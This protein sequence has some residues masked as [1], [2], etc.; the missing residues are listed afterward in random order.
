[1][2]QHE[3]I[4]EDPKQF[5]ARPQQAELAPISENSVTYV[6]HRI[7]INT[8]PENEVHN[9]TFAMCSMPGHGHTRETCEDMFQAYGQSPLF[10]V[11]DGH[12]YPGRSASEVTRKAFN[13]IFHG[14]RNIPDASIASSLLKTAFNNAHEEVNPDHDP[15]H[16]SGVCTTTLLPCIKDGQFGVMLAWLGDTRA[17]QKR[18]DATLLLTYDDNRVLP[19][20]SPDIDSLT[21]QQELDACSDAE[22]YHQKLI[23]LSQRYPH[24]S[25]NPNFEGKSVEEEYQYLYENI[26]LKYIKMFIRNFVSDC[27]G[28]PHPHPTEKYTNEFH[29]P[30]TRFIPVQPGDILLL[31]SDGV[32]DCLSTPQI[33]QA[34]SIDRDTSHQAHALVRDA[35][36]ATDPFYRKDD[37][38]AALVIKFS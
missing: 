30:H 20:L 14:L 38:R 13:P 15:E 19:T 16:S 18:G 26:G 35:H 27:I 8:G 2:S 24:P 12:G 37:D 7:G 28:K 21:I 32:T 9:I 17:Y 22:S 29:P 34:L 4:F 25:D 1:M 6:E 10:A 5:F 31:A 33:N 11:F 3:F 36:N 23:D